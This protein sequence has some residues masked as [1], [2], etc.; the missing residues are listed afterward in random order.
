MVAC[1]QRPDESGESLDVMGLQENLANHR[2]LLRSEIEH[3]IHHWIYGWVEGWHLRPIDRAVAEGINFGGLFGERSIRT[4]VCGL[5][6]TGSVE[7][8]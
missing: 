3:T 4:N 2:D 6:R 7:R 5:R 8:S 1:W